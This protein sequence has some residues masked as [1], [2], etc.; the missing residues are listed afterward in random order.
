MKKTIFAALCVLTVV[1]SF[2]V[3]SGCGSSKT[4]ATGNKPA[5]S[6]SILSDDELLSIF[7][8]INSDGGI[9]LD[10]NDVT[11]ETKKEVK[12]KAE[13]ADELV[14][15]VLQAFC[16]KDAETFDTLAA[17]CTDSRPVHYYS[18]VYNAW[19]KAADEAGLDW[20]SLTTKP[21]EW[22]A[23]RFDYPAVDYFIWFEIYY[24]P[25]S[26]YFRLYVGVD[27][28]DYN[29]ET[30]S[31][32]FVK[33]SGGRRACEL[34]VMDEYVNTGESVPNVGAAI[35][36]VDIEKYLNS[37]TIPWTSADG[38]D[39]MWGNSKKVET[40]TETAEELV[41]R[42]LQAFCEKDEK[43]IDAFAYSCTGVSRYYSDAYDQWCKAADEAGLDGK[44]LATKPEEWKVYGYYPQDDAEYYM[45]VMMF[46]PPLADGFEL[47]MGIDLDSNAETYSLRNLTFSS[48]GMDAD[49]LQ[50]YDEHVDTEGGW[51]YSVDYE[52]YLK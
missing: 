40:K 31:L 51:L 37:S 52:K 8:E 16:D 21:E 11:E 12:T 14:A 47:S 4:S 13:T 32:Y 39:A 36:S 34:Y 35:Y 23:Y 42:V 25:L 45:Q 7:A 43:T 15:N 49:S 48:I 41:A 3:L 6:S 44:N 28:F 17:S 20:K 18:D 26:D 1:F 29:T 30:Y 38:A 9:I 33:S 10:K 50:K 5:D 22:K 24:P 2:T 46:Y 19:C 27:L